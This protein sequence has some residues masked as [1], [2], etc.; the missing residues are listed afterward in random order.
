[1]PSLFSTISYLPMEWVAFEEIAIKA[2]QPATGIVILPASTIQ[3]SLAMVVELAL[4][5]MD[6]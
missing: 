1:M 4:R 3:V 6:Q 2:M 5:S